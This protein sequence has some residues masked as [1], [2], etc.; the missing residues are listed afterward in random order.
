MKTFIE[1]LICVIFGT[2]AMIIFLM[3]NGKARQKHYLEKIIYLEAYIQVSH[4]DSE[5]FNHIFDEFTEVWQLDSDHERTRKAF[6]NFTKRY[7]SEWLDVTVRD[8]SN[9]KYMEFY[10]EIMA[11]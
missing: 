11:I 5:N 10:N 1:I 3:A 6:T 9:P 8:K 7:I 2:W 4:P